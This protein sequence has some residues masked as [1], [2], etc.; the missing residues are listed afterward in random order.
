MKRASGGADSPERRPTAQF[1]KAS[2]ASPSKLDEIPERESQSLKF[3]SNE[4]ASDEMHKIYHEH[5]KEKERIRTKIEAMQRE[6]GF[7]ENLDSNEVAYMFQKKY[8]ADL[9]E[10]KEMFDMKYKSSKE[11]A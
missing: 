8:D 1:R 4:F 5:L 6:K 3:N 11:K 7:I 10:D 2:G 9:R